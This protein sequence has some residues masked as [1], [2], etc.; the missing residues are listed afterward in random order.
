MKISEAKK[1]ALE[2]M[3]KHNVGYYK[4]QFDNALVRFGYCSWRRQVISLSRNLTKLNSEAQVTDTILH[5]IAHALT[6]RHHHDKVWE[7]KAKEIGCNGMRC[8]DDS[9]QRPMMKWTRTCPTCGKSSQ[10][11]RKKSGKIACGIC[12]AGKYDAK[13]IL[14]YKLNK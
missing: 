10:V 12:C 7:T 1:L 11:S 3:K 4:F 9:V 6:P 13:H 14:I 5:E 8:Y 2:L